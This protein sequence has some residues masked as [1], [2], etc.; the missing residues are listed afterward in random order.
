MPARSARQLARSLLFV[1]L[2]LVP[3]ALA[4]G[5]PRGNPLVYADQLDEARELSRKGSWR[6]ARKAWETILSDHVG[7]QYVRPDLEEIRLEL[8]RAAFWSVTSEPR[9][10]EHLSGKLLHYDRS[11]GRIRVQYT[12][13][14]MRDFERNKVNG[15]VHY[16]F[17]AH[18]AGYWAVAAEGS[19]EELS[20]GSWLIG[21]PEQ[22]LMVR[23]GKREPGRSLFSMHTVHTYKGRSR[24][25]LLKAEP[26]E[27]D[28]D[29]EERV[30][31]RVSEREL[32][33]RIGGKKVFEA[34][35]DGAGFGEL[36]WVGDRPPRF[37]ISGKIDP[38]WLE[39]LRDKAVAKERSAFE[40]SWQEPPELGSWAAQEEPAEEEA[41]LA[42][43]VRGLQFELEMTAAQRRVF[44]KLKEPLATSH[45]G[46][47]LVLQTLPE[48]PA[49]TLPDEV[50]A[51]LETFAA[52]DLGRFVRALSRFDDLPAIPGRELELGLLEVELLRL[53]NQ[54]AEAQHELERLV[55]EHGDRALPHAQ[56][57]RVLLQQGRAGEARAVIRTA[58]ET[59]P[60]S[61]S[62]ERL[63]RQV[64]K[65]ELGPSW[66][67][68]YEHE[69]ER[70]IV[71]SEASPRVCREAA[72][73]LDG[74][75]RHCEEV[76]GPLP[77]DT[78]RSVAYVFSG[79]RGYHAYVEGIADESPE[80]TLGLYSPIL[81]QVLAWN[82]LDPDALA[83]ILRHEC[84]HRYLDLRVGNVPR[85]LNE[86]L[87]E[88]LAAEHRSDGSWD[89]ASVRDN[90]VAVLRAGG[91]GIE[92]LQSFAYHKDPAFLA[93]VERSYALSWSW[94]HFLRFEN[95][96]GQTLFEQLWSGLQ[97]GR[98]CAQVLDE[99]LAE[100]KP[101]KLHGDFVQFL[102]RLV[103]RG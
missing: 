18:F 101:D 54:L 60:A 100:G 62:L 9:L 99:A 66:K 4:Q 25:L 37:T 2:C 53:A 8:R 50:L 15:G 26:E 46:S 41:D 5:P 94:L 75:M 12:P 27:Q 23:V 92:D 40:E 14:T 11:S 97:S 13:Q 90:W 39:S 36:A 35:R 95:K 44:D 87:A 29:E 64:V 33:V 43:L 48:L 59:L 42:T 102:N 76:L 89:V 38:G 72:Q 86:G 16:R 91:E 19:I 55:E 78:P 56:L 69:G 10:D 77:Q 79:Q 93:R 34:E 96:A 21:S 30:E 57:V 68:V 17:P 45:A 88:T 73:V 20:G 49:D 58:R 31:L 3:G 82:Q 61:A 7:Q 28:A 32:E 22:G 98:D 80:S 67:R 70:F 65:A 103:R 52:V 74:M 81:K 84:V 24:W 63:E 1:A 85:W 71:R 6:K 83:D 47:L 51:Y